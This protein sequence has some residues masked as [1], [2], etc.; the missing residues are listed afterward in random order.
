MDLKNINLNTLLS[1]FP[2]IYNSNN[3]EL[4]RYLDIIYDETNG[5]IVVPVNTSGRIKGSTGEFVNVITDNL[6]VKKQ[7]TNWYE[8]YTIID[9]DYYNCYSND[10]TTYRDASIEE[11]E[12]PN[13]KYVDVTSSYY[14][15][16]NDAS[17]AFKTKNLGQTINILFDASGNS[18]FTIRLNDEENLIIQAGEALL[19]SNLSLICINVDVS[20]E[21][22]T[23]YK[24]DWIIRNRASEVDI[25]LVYQ[26]F[27]GTIS[28]QRLLTSYKN[29]TVDSSIIVTLGDYPIIGGSAEIIFI[30]D[31][32]HIPDLSTYFTKSSGSENWDS[33]AGVMNKVIFYYD[34]YKAYYSINIIS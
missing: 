29:Y 26:T 2:I 31:G 25:P 34:G 6:I 17:I 23:L 18:P 22:S 27:D 14:K 7:Y 24:S 19:T 5:V 15:I 12:D 8:N 28:L 30:A 13:Y 21:D 11:W 16:R 1:E 32:Y 33:G 4:K 10:V 9:V 20:T 3:V